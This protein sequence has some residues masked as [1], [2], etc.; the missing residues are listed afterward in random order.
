[1]R[2]HTRGEGESMPDDKDKA[3]NKAANAADNVDANDSGGMKENLQDEFDEAAGEKDEEP[4]GG[5]SAGG[6]KGN[7][8][9]E[10]DKAAGEKKDEKDNK[11]KKSKKDE[12]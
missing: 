6:L 4:E 10:F 9:D 2:L 1:M 12:D 3:P 5:K 11:D 7:L 8:K